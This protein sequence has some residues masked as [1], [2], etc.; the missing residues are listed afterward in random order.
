[1]VYLIYIFFGLTPSVIWLLFYLRKDVHPEPKRTVLK[2][3]FY[4]ALIA[5]VAAGVEIMIETC[6]NF[7][8]KGGLFPSFLLF[9]L[10]Y[11]IGIA[12]VEEFLKYFVIK[13]NILNSSKF[14]EPTDAMI[15]MIICALGFA[16]L[17]NILVLLP[18]QEVFSFL[19]ITAISSLR[20]IGATL[21][22]A[23]CSGTVGFFLALSIYETKKRFRLIFLG[24]IIA[25][26]LHGLYNFSIMRLEENFYFIY[27]P[28]IILI[29]L[30][31][32]VSFG[33]RKLKKIASVCETKEIK[34]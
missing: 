20:F 7:I 33:F 10:Y 25:T 5:L 13:K 22:H 3:F 14:D 23:L 4:G 21:L 26:I 11:F 32:F 6:L 12:F 27:I 34:N 24:L 30:A 29:G 8:N 15:Y 9:I 16:A 18:G 17:E 31:F 28:I 2:I 19:E 1:M